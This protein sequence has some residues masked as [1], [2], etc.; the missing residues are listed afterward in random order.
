MF[1]KLQRTNSHGAPVA[2]LLVQG[3]LFTLI[4]SVF[5]L[6]PSVQSAFWILSNITSQLA[7]LGYILMFSSA[8]RL[9]YKYPDVPRAYKIPG[10]KVGIWVLAGLG[11]V[12]SAVTLLIGLLPPVGIDVGENYYG[13]LLGG[14]AVLLGLPVCFF[15]ISHRRGG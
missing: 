11:L 15:A 4:C 5:L 2:V 8:I 13:L 10:G 12:S 14:H 6:S 3:I 1:T 9:R 7:L